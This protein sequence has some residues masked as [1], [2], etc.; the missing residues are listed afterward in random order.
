MPDYRVS[1]AVSDGPL[2]LLLYLIRHDEVGGYCQVWWMGI[3]SQTP[4]LSG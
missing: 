3:P 2:D 4:I 1:L